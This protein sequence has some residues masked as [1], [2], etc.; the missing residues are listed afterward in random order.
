MKVTLI[1]WQPDAADKLIFTKQTRLNMSATLM[2]EIREWPWE[3]KEQELEYIANTIRSSHEFVSYTWL[4]EDVSRAFTH[5]FVRSRLGSFAQQSMRINDMADYKFVMPKRLQGA[6]AIQDRI[7]M[8]NRL[9]KTCY[10]QLRERNIAPE[11]AR[12]ILP[13]NIATNIVARF[14][15]RAFADL[16]TS[17]AGGR[18]QDEYRDVVN[19]MIDVVLEVHPWASMFIFRDHDRDYFKDIEDFAE[20]VFA[21]DLKTKGELLKIVDK[22]RGIK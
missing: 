3:R 1:D 22:M 7:D 6:T 15:L 14:N 4:I 2:D 20:R 19:G 9:T 11:D 13:T 8:H 21:G 17:R 18:T 10:R 16:A 5:Q 12:S